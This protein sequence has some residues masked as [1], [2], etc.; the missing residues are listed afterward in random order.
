M[1]TKQL[2]E[3]DVLSLDFRIP[4]VLGGWRL[5]WSVRQLKL[6]VIADE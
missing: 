1:A 5:E 6:V 3:L 4:G 2:I